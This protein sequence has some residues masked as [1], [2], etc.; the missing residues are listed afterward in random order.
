MNRGC[1]LTSIRGVHHS[2]LVR[3]L[4]CGHICHDGEL[5]PAVV[6][7]QRAILLCEKLDRISTSLAEP[8]SVTAVERDGKVAVST[9]VH[10]IISV[11]VS[12]DSTTCNTD[13]DPKVPGAPVEPLV[14]LDKTCRRDSALGRVWEESSLPCSVSCAIV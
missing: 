11:E 1:V 7:E 5:V 4:S 2:Y 6:A 9:I 12:L 3:A 13:V 10:F 14:V 8:D